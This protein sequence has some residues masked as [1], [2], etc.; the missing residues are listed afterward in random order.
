M[1]AF[2]GGPWRRK[3]LLFPFPAGSH[4]LVPV[5]R[6]DQLHL[7]F[8]GAPLPHTASSWLPC[9]LAGCPA[10]HTEVPESSRRQLPREIPGAPHPQAVSQGVSS[11]SARE[12]G[13]LESSAGITP[14]V[15]SRVLPP[16]QGTASLH[17]RIWRHPRGN[18][19]VVS[20]STSRG[21][22]PA[23]QPQL[24]APLRALSPPQ[25]GLDLSLRGTLFQD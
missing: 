13:L 10:S 9:I 22:V 15:V 6:G 16:P 23:C 3:T 20:T 12:R 21:R 8:P 4:L 11:A 24:V 2:S 19:P 14:R 1:E 18:L 7:G 25:R 17:Q 5:A